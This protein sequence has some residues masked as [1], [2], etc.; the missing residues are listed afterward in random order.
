MP[1]K[2]LVYSGRYRKREKRRNIRTEVTKNKHLGSQAVLGAKNK[3]KIVAYNKK[4]QERGC[5]PTRTMV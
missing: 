2:V 4:M 3:R 1:V 5:A